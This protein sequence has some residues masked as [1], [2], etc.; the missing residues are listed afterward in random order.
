MAHDVV[1]SYATQDKKIA[2]AVCAGLESRGVRCWIAP[3]DVLPGEEYAKSIVVAIENCRTVVVVFSSFSNESKHVLREVEIAVKNDK[4]IIPFKIED[5]MQYFLSR[6]NSLYSINPSSRLDAITPILESHIEKLGTII[7]TLLKQGNGASPK[8]LMRDTPILTARGCLDVYNVE[9]PIDSKK[10]EEINT[11]SIGISYR[12]G[13][14]ELPCEHVDLVHFSMTSPLIVQPD[15]AFVIYIWAYLKQQHNEIIQ[16]AQEAYSDGKI[17]IQSKGP[18]KITRGTILSVRLKLEGLIVENPEDTIL[19]EGEI[20]NAT[21]LLKVPEG[22]KEGSRSGVATIYIDGMQILRLYFVIQIGATQSKVDRIPTQE[23]RYHK[24]FPSYSSKDRDAV[25]GRIQGIQK[26]APY[27]EF[28]MDVLK[29]R[30]GQYWE[31]EL[32]KIIPQNDIFYLFWSKNAC[33]SEWVEK[34]W[35]CAFKTKGID[36]I[37][38]VPLVSPEEVPP[39]PELA[40]KHFN[41]WVLSFMRGKSASSQNERDGT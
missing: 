20:G 18:V 4:I 40:G 32:W 7:N 23:E 12:V 13:N 11:G 16:R 17:S 33:K 5:V 31:Q 41:D 24:A 15:T 27:L 8:V 39:P 30:S 22:A 34:E 28:N 3:R 21:F 2:D 6:P 38:P 14:P 10:N 35:R 36:F 37:D 26:V 9:I 19:W 1:I 25:L 29:L